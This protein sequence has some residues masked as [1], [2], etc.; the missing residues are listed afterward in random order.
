[1][2]TVIAEHDGGKCEDKML[3]K[4]VPSVRIV[5]LLIFK[6]WRNKIQ[7]ITLPLVCRV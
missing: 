1:M 2:K 7:E 6:T 4:Y 3:P 5:A